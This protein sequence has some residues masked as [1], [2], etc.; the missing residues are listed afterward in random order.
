MSYFLFLYNLRNLLDHR[1]SSQ[2]G[3]INSVSVLISRVFRQP[4]GDFA[5]RL[6][7]RITVCL[8][9]LSSVLL[10]SS[11]FMGDPIT[12][13]TPAQ[14]TKQWSDFVNQYC[15]VHG[16]Y[17]VPLNESLSFLDSERRRIPINYYQ[18]VPYILAVQAFLFYMPRFIWKSLI[19]VSGYDLAGAIQYV[20]GFWN[21]VK[22]NDNTFKERI[23]AFEGRASAYI[24]DGL[25]LAR[26]KGSQDM[27][28]YYAI[29]TMLQSLNAWIQ[30][31]W[32]NSLIQ[33]PL[34]TLWGPS[35]VYDLLRGDDWQVTGHF[36]RV[37]HCDFN[38]RRPASVQLDTVLC[39][40]TLNIYY[41]KLFIFLWF[42]LLFVAI[43]S[44]INSI[45]WILCLFISTKARRIITDYLA[46]DPNT[47]PG[48]LSTEQFFMLL[49]KDG[50][51]VLQQMSLNLGDIPA[52][53]LS[54]AM[55]NIGERW[56]DE[57]NEQIRIIEEKK[58]LKNFKSV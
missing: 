39:V 45:Y 26:N 20:D 12:C 36:P 38:R 17:F 30:W 6:N 34:Y 2:V 55:R 31:Y 53:Y 28:L 41:E 3:A 14:F 42:W 5:D 46:T 40:L 58:P 47:Q 7:S 44:I 54:I 25:R 35:L 51:F 23:A 32:L 19:A 18:W 52:S 8:L 43:V 50:L 48:R 4:K 22:S 49:G 1:M 57:D 9:S 15:Y 27:A 56:M 21:T 29:S 37:T 13:W 10:L 33:S 11:H 16:T 24:W